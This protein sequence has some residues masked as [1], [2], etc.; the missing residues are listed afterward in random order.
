MSLVSYSQ[1]L[2]STTPS[3]C[4]VPCKALKNALLMNEDYLALKNQYQIKNDSIVNLKEIVVK[5]DELLSNKNKEI[6]LMRSNE[7]SYKGIIKEKDK[8]IAE[9]QRKYK[10]GKVKQYTS[11]GFGLLVAVAGL[12]IG[13]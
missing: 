1:K 10:I 13:L 12:V 11:Y 3:D 6:D 8:Q 4:I 2:S 5:K 9:Y 7:E